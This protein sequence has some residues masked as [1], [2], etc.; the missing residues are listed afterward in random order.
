MA[1]EVLLPKYH[2]NAIMP[3][4][5]MMKRLMVWYPHLA[6]DMEMKRNVFNCSYPN[7]LFDSIEMKKLLADTK[8]RIDNF[9]AYFNQLYFE[10]EDLLKGTP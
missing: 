4:F 7:E 2:V 3:L 9:E 8:A 5:M 1:S 6:R 10:L